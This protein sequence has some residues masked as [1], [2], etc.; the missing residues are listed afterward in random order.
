MAAKLYVFLFIFLAFSQLSHFG[1]LLLG[2]PLKV[3]IRDVFRAEVL[4]R[5]CFLCVFCCSQEYTATLYLFIRYL[6]TS[7]DPQHIHIY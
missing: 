2:E 5:V 6:S 3:T 1:G 4:H 7:A